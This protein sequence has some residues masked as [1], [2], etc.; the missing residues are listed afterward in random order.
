MS[1]VFLLALLVLV[2]LLAPLPL[3]DFWVFILVEIMVYSLYAVSFNLLLGYGGMLAFG[4]AMFF[5]LGAYTV[6][7]L[8]VKLGVNVLAAGVAAPLVA[9][10]F[11]AIIGYF[12][13]RLSGIYLGMLTF[14]F[15]MLAY[16]VFVKFYDL[17]GGDDGLHGLIIQ[18]IIGKPLGIYYLSLFIVTACILLLHRIVRSPFSLALRAQHSNI[19][20]SLAIGIN[21]KLE[22]W[23][24]FVISAFFA[25][26]A[27]ALSAL[28]T[29]SVF[30]DLLDWRASA[31]PI[32]MAILGGTHRFIGPVIGAFIYVVLQTVV[33]GYTEY[34]SMV[35][36][37]LIIAIVMVAP[38]GAVS[39]LVRERP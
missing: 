2:S 13:V 7:I 39:F 24:A 29:Q 37:V 35:M 14:A 20:K 8:Q 28:A 15:Q 23:L 10:G 12:C 27:G 6:A 21:V 5:G 32:V 4:F 26:I 19:N 11:G 30:P 18:G 3:S 1:K 25:G 36:G 31:V 22:K 9:A 17:A 34:W 33:T 38:K 16:S